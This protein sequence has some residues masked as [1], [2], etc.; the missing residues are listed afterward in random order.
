LLKLREILRV[1]RYV[2]QGVPVPEKTQPS[3]SDPEGFTAEHYS[4]L[5]AGL[6][7]KLNN[8]LTVLSGHSGLLLL[9]P[10]L[11][12]D[13]LQPIEQMSRAAA[14]LS[15]YV[16][17]AAIVARALPLRPEAVGLSELFGSLESPPG[18]ST[19]KRINGRLKV[20]ADR[21]RLKEIFEQIL[22]N[23][24]EANASTTTVTAEIHG[25]FVE[26]GFRD[27]GHGIVPSV[28]SRV[29]EPFFT[30]RKS[31]ENFGLGLFRARGDLTR[32]KGQISAESDGKTYT[33]ILVRLPAG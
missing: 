23:A 12:G 1:S 10:N 6:I 30:T 2:Y 18:L 32:M 24:K 13:I 4:S 5:L 25:E 14:T 29:F 31:E 27:D 3:N 8:I 7:H 16:D 28:M 11:R 15:R 21:R 20:L 33:E 9:D 22:L 26:I 19:R 17:E